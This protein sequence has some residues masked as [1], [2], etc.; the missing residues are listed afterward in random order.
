MRQYTAKSS[1]AVSIPE[2]DHKKIR[3]AG[4]GTELWVN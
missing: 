3:L 2:K 4:L 1:K